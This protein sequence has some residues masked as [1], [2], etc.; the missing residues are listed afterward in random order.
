MQ[1]MQTTSDLM[2]SMARFSWAMSMVAARSMTKMMSQPTD[3]SMK[4]VANA[5]GR[6]LSGAIKTTF[7]VGT[8]IQAGVVDAAFDLAGMGAKGQKAPSGTTSALA[9][10][11]M[12]SGTRRVAGVRTV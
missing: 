10:P 7:A 4:S 8:N 6:Q 11:L 9:V 3:G 5:V 1:M 12:E 2:K